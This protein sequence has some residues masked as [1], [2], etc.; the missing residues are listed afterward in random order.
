M[1]MASADATAAGAK[2]AGQATAGDDNDGTLYTG[3]PSTP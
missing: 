1:H 3:E 2:F